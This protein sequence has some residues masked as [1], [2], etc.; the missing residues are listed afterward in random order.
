[1]FQE[2]LLCLRCLIEI[3][4]VLHALL[5]QIGSRNLIEGSVYQPIEN[6]GIIGDLHTSALIGLDGSIDWLCFPHFDSPTIFGA[7]LDDQKGGWFR[8]ETDPSARQ[9]QF[10]LPETNV[11]VTR[12]L[13]KDGVLEIIDYMPIFPHDVEETHHHQLIR[14]IKVVRGTMSFHIECKPAFDYAR[15]DHK[16]VIENNIARFDS[17]DLDLQLSATRDLE[18]QE[19]A[20][21]AEFILHEGEEET[22]VLERDGRDRS[23]EQLA[24]LHEELLHKTIKYWQGWL[25]YS[26]YQGRWRETVDRSALLLKLLTFQPTGAIVAAPTTSL[27]EEIGGERNWD[28][29]YTWVRDAAFTLYGLL[30]IGFTE[31]ASRFMHWIEER[32]HELDPDDSLQIMYGLDGHHDLSEQHL[33]HLN[34][35]RDSKPVRIGNGAFNQLQLDIYGELLD[36]VYLYNKYGSPISFDLWQQLTRLLDYVCDHWQEPDEGIWEVR[37][38]KQR[39]VY[40]MLMCWVAL[41]RGLRLAQKRSFPA[42]LDKWLKV[43]NQIYYTIM[44]KGWSK[45]RKAFVQYIGSNTLDASTLLMPLVFFVSPSDPRMLQTIDAINQSPHKGGLV[46]DSLVYRYNTKE[47]YDGVSGDEGTFN[48]C[49]FWLVEALTRAGRFDSQRLREARLM[50]EKMLGY[51]N[52]VGLYAEEIGPCGEALGNYPQAFTHLSLI[53]AAFNLNRTLG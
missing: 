11:L 10:Y 17:P 52:H 12:F 42:D 46:A 45:K 4:S 30:R 21:I 41:D 18:T 39:F 36:T 22:F 5:I 8:I 50:F 48:M 51:A 26:S 7:I 43:R 3:L 47:S 49:S 32:C 25:S 33:D 38:G 27:P 28:Y 31:E 37:S 6:Y 2:I 14:H 9:K 44:K 34:G 53:S 16:L 40:S 15:Q 20:A 23:P 13:A 1:M 19:G 35:Y 24:N 29:R